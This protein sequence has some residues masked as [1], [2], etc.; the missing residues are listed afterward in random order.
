MGILELTPSIRADTEAFEKALKELGWSK[1]QY[2][3][4]IKRAGLS[5]ADK[6]STK[7]F[8]NHHLKKIGSSFQYKNILQAPTKIATETGM[9]GVEPGK[10]GAPANE[11]IWR[12]GAKIQKVAEKKFKNL[13]DQRK[14]FVETMKKLYKN[15][16]KSKILHIFKNIL[17]GVKSFSPIGLSTELMMQMMEKNPELLNMLNNKIDPSQVPMARKGGMMDIN[18]MTRPLGYANGGF[19]DRM[20]MLRESMMDTENQKMREPDIT[21]V[22]MTIAQQEGD[23][24]EENINLIIRQLEALMPSLTKTMEKELT[25][26]S[27]QGLKYLFDKMNIATGRKSDPRLNR[28]VGFGRVE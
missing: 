3:R 2:H 24:S 5:L 11:K 16:P 15:V 13:T 7:N 21:S 25:P 20:S 18:E 22:A 14:Y 1:D 23:T 8:L 10:A 4:K 27:T 28:S 12:D 17:R 6:T 9:G 26:L 19:E